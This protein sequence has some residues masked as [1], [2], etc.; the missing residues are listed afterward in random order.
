MKKLGLKWLLILVLVLILSFTFVACSSKN[1]G[2]VPIDTTPDEPAQEEEI[3]YKEPVLAIVSKN[4]Q[5]PY[6]SSIINAAKLAALANDVKISTTTAT[7]ALLARGRGRRLSKV[8]LIR[9]PRER[10]PMLYVAHVSIVVS[11]PFRALPCRTAMV[12]RAAIA[13]S[14]ERYIVSLLATER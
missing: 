8:R 3:V 4:E 14:S 6:E 1:K 12:A 7:F 5:D 2:G 10:A 11:V 9:H 13:A